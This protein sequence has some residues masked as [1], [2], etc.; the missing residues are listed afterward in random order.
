MEAIKG[1][2]YKREE[3]KE[4]GLYKYLVCLVLITDE[5]ITKLENETIIMDGLPGQELSNIINSFK[6]YKVPYT[7]GKI[8]SGIIMVSNMYPTDLEQII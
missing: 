6:K 8:S 3:L 5:P 2:I 7:M 1:L 4:E